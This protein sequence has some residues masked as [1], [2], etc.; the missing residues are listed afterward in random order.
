MLHLLGFHPGLR[1]LLNI[2]CRVPAAISLGG[3]LAGGGTPVPENASCAQ[4][5][6]NHIRQNGEEEEGSIKVSF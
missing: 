4:V 5:R 1:L 6:Q 3:K 2:H